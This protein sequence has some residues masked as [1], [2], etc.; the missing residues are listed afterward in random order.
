MEIVRE[1][2]EQ[3]TEMIWGRVQEKLSGEVLHSITG[4]LKSSI[5]REVVVVGDRVTGRVFSDGSV[6]YAQIHEHGGTTSPH[7]ILVRGARALRFEVQGGGVRFATSVQHPGSEIPP[8]SY[9]G[10]TLSE[11]GPMIRQFL[12]PRG[13]P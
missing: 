9:L 10:S 1:R 2:M 13:I 4:R 6:P 11:F 5:T 7:T 3:L 8:R 12:T